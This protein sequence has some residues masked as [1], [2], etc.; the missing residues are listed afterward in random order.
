MPGDLVAKHRRTAVFAI[1]LA[2]T[3]WTA[4]GRG[5]IYSRLRPWSIVQRV[6]APRSWQ[7]LIPQCPGKIHWEIFYW[8][9]WS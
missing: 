3:A 1:N 5:C 4:A 2:S 9:G 6:S 7:S 8:V